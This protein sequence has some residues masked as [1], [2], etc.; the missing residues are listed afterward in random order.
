MG[1]LAEAPAPDFTPAPAGERCHGAARHPL[2]IPWVPLSYR[3]SVFLSS[4]HDMGNQFSLLLAL[5]LQ[6]CKSVPK[7]FGTWPELWVI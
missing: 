1:G 6:V 2:A 7:V 3:D 5:G 4:Q